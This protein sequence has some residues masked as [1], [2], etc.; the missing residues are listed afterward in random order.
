MANA[1]KKA[2][3]SLVDKAFT[4]EGYVLEV[5]KWEPATMYEIDF[6]MP[7]TDMTKWNTIPRIKCKVAEFEYRDYTPATWDAEKK[8][9]TVL[10]ETEHNGYGS[11]WAKNL[12]S[13]DTILFAPAHAAPLP[14]KP[15]KIFCFGDGSAVGHFL[16]LKQLTDRKNYPLE[17]V[18]FLNEAYIIPDTFLTANPEFKFIMLPQGRSLDSL[19][20]V[21]EKNPLSAYTSVYIAGYIP[22]VQGLRKIF[23]KNQNLS[24]RLFAHGFWS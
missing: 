15:G 20:L 4:Q 17:V 19:S 10:I 5:R 3:F 13:G 14:A 11:A 18:V 12:Q 6:Y 1:I 22:M 23:K 24:A 8:I 2:V 7:E 16:A 9:C 21:A